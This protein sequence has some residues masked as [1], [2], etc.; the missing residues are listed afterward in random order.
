MPL[1]TFQME[2]LEEATATYEAEVNDDVLEWWAARGIEEQ[3]VRTARLGV[4]GTDP[5]PGHDRYRGWIAIPYLS[6][7]GE[8]LQIRFRCP[9]K[10]EHEHHGKYETVAGD[11]AR[12]YNTDAIFWAGDEIHVTEGEID[13]LTL[14][15]LGLPAVAIPGVNN[16]KA[17]HRRM[18]AGFSTVYVWGDGD[19][20]GSEFSGRVTS[21]MRTAKAVR[22]PRDED[23]NSLY[24][25]HGADAVLDLIK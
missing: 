18:L 23:V 21:E 3:A 4:V 17:R 1:S 8:V 7:K 16:W 11:P 19:R 24:V 14:H 25:K 9:L 6:H 10:H 12:T 2:A 22:V 5:L 13:T 20:A 15:Q